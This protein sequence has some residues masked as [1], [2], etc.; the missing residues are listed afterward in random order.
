MF[1]SVMP[2]VGDVMETMAH[3]HVPVKEAALR[4]ALVIPMDKPDAVCLEGL[5]DNQE[6]LMTNPLPPEY[7]RVFKMKGKK[8]GKKKKK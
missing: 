8:G 2:Q 7:W 6:G 4:K 5:R 3:Y 1:L